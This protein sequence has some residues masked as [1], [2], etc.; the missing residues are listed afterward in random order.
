MW[1]IF[2]PKDL[3]KIRA[4]KIRMRQFFFF[5]KSSYVLLKCSVWYLLLFFPIN[6]KRFV[7]NKIFYL[8]YILF[9]TS[10]LIEYFFRLYTKTF[11]GKI[12]TNLHRVSPGNFLGKNFNQASFKNY[13]QKLLNCVSCKKNW[14]ANANLHFSLEI[15]SV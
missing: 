13:R 3:E 9:I 8:F 14:R 10:K 5:K 11:G 6:H 2:P 4:L 15:F 12:W 1:R 7:F